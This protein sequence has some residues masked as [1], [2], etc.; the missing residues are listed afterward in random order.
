M[1]G[2][3]YEVPPADS[4]EFSGID[5]AVYARENPFLW[6][7]LAGTGFSDEASGVQSIA[8]AVSQ[9]TRD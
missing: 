4:A 9:R 7:Y 6:G 3:T 2:G 1:T 5:A 8:M